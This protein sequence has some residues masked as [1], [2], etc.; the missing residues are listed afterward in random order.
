M[1]LLHPCTRLTLC[2][3]QL[4]DPSYSWSITPKAVSG[5]S[6]AVI[7]VA[8]GDLHTCVVTA[9]GAFC[10]GY[11]EYGQVNCTR[12]DPNV[13]LHVMFTH[14]RSVTVWGAGKGDRMR[15]QRQ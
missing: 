1:I 10:F 9:L 7:A 15:F 6:G 8:A 11:N 5:I 13:V 12:N 2:S 14:G 3:M 4:G